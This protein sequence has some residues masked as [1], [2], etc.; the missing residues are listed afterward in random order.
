[1][2]PLLEL[3]S[4]GIHGGMIVSKPQCHP[5]SPGG[6][7]AKT[8]V[9]GAHTW[10]KSCDKVNLNRGYVLC[11]DGVPMASHPN[12][13]D[14]VIDN[15][16]IFTSPTLSCNS[17]KKKKKL[18]VSIVRVAIGGYTRWDDGVQTAMSSEGSFRS[19]RQNT[20]VGRHTW[21]QRN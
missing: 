17:V 18:N 2:F 21:R 9:V 7:V 20:A 15:S 14:E 12:S 8:H 16:H 19:C 3:Q 11:D 1:M 10:C 4:E 13:C 6:V 5:S